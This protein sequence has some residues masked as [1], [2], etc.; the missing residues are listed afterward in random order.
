MLNLERLRALHAVADRGSVNAAAQALH[1]TTSAISQQLAKLETEIGQPLLER[2]GRGVRL[3]DAATL[4]VAHTSEVL[5]RLERAEAELDARRDVVSGRL[6]VAAFATAV[7]GLAPQALR[8]LLTAHA[9]LEVVLREQ[10]PQESVPQ[11]VRGD[12]DLLIAQD[13]D[14]AP[15]ALP[16]GLERAPIVD[17]VADVALPVDHRLAGRE[18]L[19]LD[20]LAGERW[21]AWQ[22][23]T[24]CHD[25][26]MHTLRSR[27]HEPRLTHTAGEHASQLALV[28]A[29]LG[30]CVVPRLGR[31]AVPPGVR[32]VPVKPALRR[33]VY[34]LWRSETS[35][36]KAIAAA[37]AAFQT[38]ASA[39]VQ[40]GTRRSIPS[41]KTPGSR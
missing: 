18:A 23:G 30:C 38:S 26:L 20:E 33:H 13:W 15:L 35:R 8:H 16:D 34:A 21:I 27:G 7:R 25:W 22:A 40:T 29:G 11:L 9:Q 12:L 14:N 19:A 10:E 17:D 1:V 3:T 36:R 24:I 2:N 6:T 32:I 39:L 31:G 41:R 4:L 37:V 28:G 5:A